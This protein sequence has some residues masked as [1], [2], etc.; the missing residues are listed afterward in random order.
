MGSHLGTDTACGTTLRDQ[1]YV[2]L[3]LDLTFNPGTPAA[4]FCTQEHFAFCENVPLEC[5]FYYAEWQGPH[6]NQT[7]HLGNLLR[8]GNPLT[9][10]NGAKHCRGMKVPKFAAKKGFVAE[11]K[12][13]LRP[14]NLAETDSPIEVKSA[15]IG[16]VKKILLV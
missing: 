7:E 16:E 3:P 4:P 1:S 14:T 6:D 2:K 10:R 11:I 8:H 15:K 5:G 9:W 13:L 12:R